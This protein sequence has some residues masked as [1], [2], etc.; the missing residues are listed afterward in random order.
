[1]I[2]ADT[3]IWIAYLEGSPG[4][5]VDAFELALSDQVL[6]MAPVVLAELL[7]DPALPVEVA[8][9]LSS[10]PSL[11]L[12]EGYWARAGKLRSKMLAGGLR[13]KLADTLIAQT[14]LDHDAVLLTRDTGFRAYRAHGLKLF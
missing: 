2:I 5:D 3:N 12:S 13:P 4:K 14:C 9:D 6:R 8:A 11:E 10:I 1:M 7:S